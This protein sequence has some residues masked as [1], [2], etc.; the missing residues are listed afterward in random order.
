MWHTSGMHEEVVFENIN[1]ERASKKLRTS[2]TG[3]TE[4]AVDTV[5]IRGSV[6]KKLRNLAVG[7]RGLIDLKQKAYWA[8]KGS[9]RLMIIVDNIKGE[10]L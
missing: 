2:D 7:R 8:L 9:Q 4:E 5:A 10:A 3:P 6:S 1:G